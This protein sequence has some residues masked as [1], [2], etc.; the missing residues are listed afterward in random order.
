MNNT[1]ILFPGQGAQAVGMGKDLA[2]QLPLCRGL[3]DRAGE[4]LGFDLA[5]ICFEGP[6]EELT[7]SHHA[8]PAIF[9]VSMAAYEALKAQ[10]PELAPAA[11]AGLSSGEW[12]AL[13]AAGVVSFEDA[14]RVLEA[15]GRF[16][17]SACEQTRGGMMSVIGLEVSRVQEI[18]EQA[19]VQVANLNSPE[20]TVLSGTVEGIEKAEPLA[21]AAG[22]KRAIRLNVSGAFHSRL[23]EPAAAKLDAFLADIAMNEPAVPVVS[24]VTGAPFTSVSEIRELMVKQ[25]TH[26]VR[27]VDDIR[28]IGAQG[29]QQY[30]ECGPGKVLAG[31]LKRIDKEAT[32]HNIHDHGSLNAASGALL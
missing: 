12:A 26:S 7:R 32:I 2:D 17:Q 13:H 8:Q 24:N 28:W 21:K 9:A 19:G 25:V 23:M 15:R 4:V 6:E 1:A 11:Y 18:A 29:I 31:L 30:V 16:M 5:Q 10:R 27:W 22:A 20:Q 3:F 14:L